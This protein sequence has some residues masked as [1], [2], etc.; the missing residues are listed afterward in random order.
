MDIQNMMALSA[1][2]TR[3][4]FEEG[5][6]YKLLQKI[7]FAPS[8]FAIVERLQKNRDTLT[9]TLHFERVGT[10]YA[11][12]YYDVALVKAIV[13]PERTINAISLQQLDRAMSDI[14]WRS[15][16]DSRDILLGDEKTWLR[17]KNISLVIGQLGRLSSTEEG[18]P[19]A[20]ALKVKHWLDAGLEELIGNLNA[21]RAK[22]EISQRVYF[23]EGE[24]IPVAEVYRF[25]LNRWME[26]KMQ[27]K[28]K[29]GVGGHGPG[30]ADGNV[31]KTMKLSQ[32]KSRGRVKHVK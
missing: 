12:P 17:E 10:G 3:A 28:R 23:I 7:C 30:E 20:D 1:M 25:L 26:K 16:S 9:C 18:K 8:T 4:G 22:V 19:F 31:T 13:M 6:S 14:D 5:I 27:A 2:L 15:Q 29:A 21:L 24:A 11:C 32:K